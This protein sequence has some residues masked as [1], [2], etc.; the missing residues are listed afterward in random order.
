MRKLAILTFIA[1]T[2]CGVAPAQ[3]HH[4]RHH[5]TASRRVASLRLA[6]QRNATQHVAAAPPRNSSLW[7]WSSDNREQRADREPRER[8]AR[9][10]RSADLSGGDPRPRAWCGWQMRRLVGSDPGPSYNLA[11]N[12]A[13]WGR[14]GPAGIGAV[15]V[16]PHHV[17]KI[18]GQQNG[19]WVVESGNDGHQLRSRPRSIA[20]AIAIRWG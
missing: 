16:W 10:R 1:A 3:A 13:H 2:L 11:R 5:R 18:V 9:R 19:Q 7:A 17:G 4:Y 15:V 6:T 14:A 8:V 20:G 12:W